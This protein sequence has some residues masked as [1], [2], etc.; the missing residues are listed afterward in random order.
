MQIVK[1]S[2]SDIG[3]EVKVGPLQKH[4]NTANIIRKLAFTKFQQTNQ[5]FKRLHQDEEEFVLVYKDGSK[6][7]QLPD[8]SGE[9]T[10]F[11]YRK[12]IDPK[13]KY[14]RIRLFLCESC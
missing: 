5:R 8:Q 12:F 13:M 2:T 10:L 9:F 4:L 6:V 1:T 3:G 14:E 11:S 7:D